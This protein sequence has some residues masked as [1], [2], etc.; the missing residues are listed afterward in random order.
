MTL[1]SA[2]IATLTMWWLRETPLSDLSIETC[3]QGAS[4]PKTLRI[5]NWFGQ[6]WNMP[7]QSGTRRPT[8][9][10]VDLKLCR[11]EQPGSSAVY[12]VPTGKPAQLDCSKNSLQPLFHRRNDRRIKIFSQYHHSSKGVINNYIKTANVSSVRRHDS[13]YFIP[14]SNT[15]HYQRSFF[16]R[17]AKDWNALPAGN[18][19]LVPPRV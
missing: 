5:N 19:L 6:S 15:L 14:T 4:Q 16:I 1:R 17:T 10:P 2:G 11:R 13:Q 9:L 3:S 12:G 18:P 8:L 7:L